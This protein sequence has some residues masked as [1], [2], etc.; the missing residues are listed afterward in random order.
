[1]Q[2]ATEDCPALW[3]LRAAYRTIGPQ[4]NPTLDP[5]EGDVQRLPAQPGAAVSV[6]GQGCLRG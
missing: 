2:E 6:V 3:R 1:M 4:L 5:Q